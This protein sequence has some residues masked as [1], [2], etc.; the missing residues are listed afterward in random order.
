L[1][2]GESAFQA[3]LR[4]GTQPARHGV[5]QLSQGVRQVIDRRFAPPID[6]ALGFCPLNSVTLTGLIKPSSISAT[7]PSTVSTIFP[8]GPSVEMA[9]SRMRD[10]NRAKITTDGARRFGSISSATSA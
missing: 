6:F 2:F 4:L 8:I 5:S 7:M 1:P 9:G 3:E 10:E